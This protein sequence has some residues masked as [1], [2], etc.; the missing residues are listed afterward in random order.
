MNKFEKVKD[1]FDKHL[2]GISAV[3]RAVEKGWITAKQFTEITGEE[4]VPLPI[5][6]S[7]NELKEANDILMNGGGAT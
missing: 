2:W 7:Y 6:P 4:Y 5:E 1:Y 3:N